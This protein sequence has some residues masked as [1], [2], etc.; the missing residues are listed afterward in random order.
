MQNNDAGKICSLCKK[1]EG[2]FLE[3]QNHFVDVPGKNPTPFNRNRDIF[4]QPS[5]EIGNKEASHKDKKYYKHKKDKENN[6]NRSKYI[7]EEFKQFKKPEHTNYNS[8][9]IAYT[10]NMLAING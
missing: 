10:A 8:E 5:Q 3:I 6:G 4:I 9:D 1:G 7:S 2:V